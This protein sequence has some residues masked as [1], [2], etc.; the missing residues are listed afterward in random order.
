MKPTRTLDEAI[1][2]GYVVM[3]DS[4]RI[5]NT[6]F[7]QCERTDD[8]YVKVQLKTT[9][10]MVVVDLIGQS[11]RMSEHACAEIHGLLRTHHV[12]RWSW[13]LASHNR[14]IMYSPR[15]PF[16]YAESVAG[17]IV[18][19]LNKPGYREPNDWRTS[20]LVNDLDRALSDGSLLEMMPA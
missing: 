1:N 13:H 18:S 8:P 15:I 6:F 2:Q 17:G 4:Y 10:A 7:H 9:Y 5:A 14:T 3:R 20:Q 12:G 16:R 19:I 11:Y